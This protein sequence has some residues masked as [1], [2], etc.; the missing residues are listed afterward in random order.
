MLVCIFIK[1]FKG[2]EQRHLQIHERDLWLVWNQ[3][4]LGILEI[5]VRHVQRLQDNN[6]IQYQSILNISHS[7]GKNKGA[8]MLQNVIV[9]VTFQKGSGKM[10]KSHFCCMWYWSEKCKQSCVKDKI[11]SYLK[12]TALPHSHCSCGLSAHQKYVYMKKYVLRRLKRPWRPFLQVAIA[13][14]AFFSLYQRQVKEHM[15]VL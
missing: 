9:S 6:D 4:Q 12:S 8:Y 10:K 7:R 13:S 5:R 15:K 1:Y 3:R 11:S 2:E 14:L